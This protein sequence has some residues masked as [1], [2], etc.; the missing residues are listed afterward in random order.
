[1]PSA[2]EVAGYLAGSVCSKVVEVERSGECL[3]L[4]CRNDPNLVIAVAEHNGWIYI[5]AVPEQGLPAHMWH[6]DQV[7]YT[8]YGVYAFARRVEDV[9]EKLRSK[10]GLLKAIARLAEERAAAMG[11]E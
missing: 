3:L 5:K 9:V 2:K 1:M 6:C 4:Y 10:L 7:Y 8:P 11:V